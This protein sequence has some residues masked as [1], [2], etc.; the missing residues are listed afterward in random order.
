MKLRNYSSQCISWKIKICETDFQNTHLFFGP[1]PNLHQV[2]CLHVEDAL[3]LIHRVKDFATL[4]I[5]LK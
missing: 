3:G 5:G 1:N 2:T 4:Y